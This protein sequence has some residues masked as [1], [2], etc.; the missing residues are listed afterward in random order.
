MEKSWNFISKVC[1][2]NENLVAT[3]KTTDLDHIVKSLLR[4]LDLLTTDLYWEYSEINS[5]FKIMKVLGLGGGLHSP[6]AL[7]L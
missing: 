4:L 2:L 7:A 5:G 6:C 3:L 1:E